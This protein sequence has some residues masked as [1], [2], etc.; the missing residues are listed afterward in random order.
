[1]HLR[2]LPRLILLLALLNATLVSAWHV[3][4]HEAVD[5]FLAGSVLSETSRDAADH[6]AP[7]QTSE[8]IC[9]DCL[10]LAQM[11]AF[12]VPALRQPLPVA[13]LEGARPQDDAPPSGA[14][15]A[16]LHRFAARAPPVRAGA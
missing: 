6:D 4:H 11:G 5:G 8:A 3:H 16:A 10:V 15:H 12:V 7:A 14:R 13:P 1:M 2:F 9:L